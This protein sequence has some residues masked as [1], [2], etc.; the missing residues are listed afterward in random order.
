MIIAG[1]AKSSLIDYPGQVACV[2][3]LPGCNYDCFYCH[4][5]S[6]ID[7]TY[8]TV[9]AED[10]FSFLKKRVKQLDGVVIT[11]GEPTLQ[12]DLFP[13]IEDIRALGYKIKLDTNGTSPKAVSYALAEDLCDYYA[14]DYKA[15]ASR[16]TEFCG[17][18]ADAATVLQTIRILKDSGAQFEVRTTVIPQLTLNDLLCMARELPPLPRYVLNRYRKPEKYLPCDKPKLEQT[19]YTQAQ[20]AAF[21]PAIRAFQPNATT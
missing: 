21:L 14:V 6:L 13:F 11:G 19:P 17:Q 7:G 10:I 3:F 16:Y 18:N 20:I 4:N 5:R 2:L 1:I 9:P 15:P 8:E 12:Q